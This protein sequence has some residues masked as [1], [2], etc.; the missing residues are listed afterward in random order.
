V[1]YCHTIALLMLSWNLNS[2]LLF[3]C[4]RGGCDEVCVTI[5]EDGL[6]KVNT[7]ANGEAMAA[8]PE[9]SPTPH[10]LLAQNSLAPPDSNVQAGDA[11]DFASLLQLVQGVSEA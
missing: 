11:A 6:L 5:S 3:W 4:C 7:F 1:Y 10:V 2:I 8:A 9:F